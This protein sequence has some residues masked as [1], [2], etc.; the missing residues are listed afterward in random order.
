MKKKFYN[1]NTKKVGVGESSEKRKKQELP[2]NYRNIPEKLNT[3]RTV[4]FVGLV[5]MLF[6]ILLISLDIYL[7]FQK[8]KN[9]TNEK[10]RVIREISFWENETVARSN[11]RDGYMN[12]ALLNFQVK[13][14]KEARSNLKKVFEL[15]PN[16]EKGRQLER[17]LDS[18]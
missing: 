14:F 3:D 12:L 10:F 17:L 11:Y 9:L 4:F 18:F 13:N 15:D 2:S 16:F 5:V 1:K 6:A 7:N 8:Q